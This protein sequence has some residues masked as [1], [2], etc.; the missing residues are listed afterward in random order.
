MDGGKLVRD[1]AFEGGLIGCSLTDYQRT[2]L[3]CIEYRW[4]SERE[5]HDL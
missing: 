3:N 5:V 2:K 4:E 1:E